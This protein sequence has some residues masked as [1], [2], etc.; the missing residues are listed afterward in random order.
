MQTYWRPLKAKEGKKI[1]K[2]HCWTDLPGHLS[3]NSACG[4]NSFRGHLETNTGFEDPK[5]RCGNCKRA[6][7]R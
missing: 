1:G 3:I 2:S 5:D 4:K 6:L 7:E